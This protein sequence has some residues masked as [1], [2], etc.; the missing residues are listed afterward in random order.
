MTIIVELL[1]QSKLVIPNSSIQATITKMLKTLATKKET[2]S[3]LY[4]LAV[5]LLNFCITHHTQAANSLDSEG[6]STAILEPEITLGWTKQGTAIADSPG[7][8]VRNTDESRYLG[9]SSGYPK[10]NSYRAYGTNG[11]TSEEYPIEIE[12]GADGSP[13]DVYPLESN[14]GIV[15][16]YSDL[17]PS[18]ANDNTAFGIRNGSHVVADRAELHLSRVFGPGDP[19]EI[20]EGDSLWVGYSQI[21]THLDFNCR[22]HIFQYHHT[23]GTGPST[24]ILLYPENDQ[25]FF[26][27]EQRKGPSERTINPIDNTTEHWQIITPR[28]EHLN[29]EAKVGTWYTF[30]MNI[31]YSRTDEGYFKLWIY[32][33]NN[34][35]ISFN[36][37]DEPSYS[38][39]GNTMYSVSTNDEDQ[40]EVRLG[41]YRWCRK[42]PNTP[43][44]DSD[45]YINTY[46]GPLRF[47]RSND[48]NDFYR[49]AP[50]L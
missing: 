48:I 15:R 7:L 12:I 8:K 34:E 29:Q 39:Q 35:A 20:E 22:T 26:Q 5:T 27:V 43:T 45:R 25:L 6:I 21:F 40:F 38:R 10:E 19:L 33:H 4:L 44:N 11:L 30:I 28:N 32:E 42:P 1:P 3:C 24:G 46:I 23:R 2:L 36:H 47:H 37:L 16:L 50:R 49:V 41:Q 17:W 18:W 9:A 13:F 31:K 14:Q